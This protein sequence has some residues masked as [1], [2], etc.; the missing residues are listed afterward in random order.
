MDTRARTDTCTHACRAV[1]LV[2]VADAGAA[3][4]AGVCTGEELVR[5]LIR[6]ERVGQEGL[7]GKFCIH[8]T[9]A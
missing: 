2:S 5:R 6:E 4:V 7:V 3:V 9:V 8:T 1:L